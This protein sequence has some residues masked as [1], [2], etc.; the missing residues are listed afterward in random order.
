MYVIHVVHLMTYSNDLHSARASSI[1]ATSH[2]ATR[3]SDLY[4]MHIVLRAH[5]MSMHSLMH[6]RAARDHV[7][8]HPYCLRLLHNAQLR[9]F[10]YGAFATSATIGG[11]TALTQLAASASGQPDALPL[12]QCLTN[13]AIDFGVVATCAFGYRFES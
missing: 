4:S 12:T 8:H 7:H 11:F 3:M 9:L 5:L 10:V 6:T 2:H 13:V 1:C